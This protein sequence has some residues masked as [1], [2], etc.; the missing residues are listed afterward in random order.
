M[1]K[2]H[3]NLP[4][5]EDT[6]SSK[7]GAELSLPRSRAAPGHAWLWLQTSSVT[8]DC[9]QQRWEY[10]SQAGGIQES[11]T[12]KTELLRL[13]LLGYLTALPPGLVSLSMQV[14]FPPAHVQAWPLLLS[15]TEQPP[16][17]PAGLSDAAAVSGSSEPSW[18]YTWNSGEVNLSL[19]D[20]EHFCHG[21]RV[22]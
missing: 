3:W 16:P 15:S 9:T 13:G 21:E 22:T 7:P 6:P 20:G 18:D 14:P 19:R 11:F 17:A 10:I 4:K 2:W 12:K 5:Q 8:G 1:P